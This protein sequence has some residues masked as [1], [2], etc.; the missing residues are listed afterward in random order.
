MQR[1]VGQITQ[2]CD[3]IQSDILVFSDILHLTNYVLGRTKHVS[4]H[5][6]S[7]VVWALEHTVNLLAVVKYAN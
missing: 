3:R 2:R 7:L 5:I 6:N 1:I 4:W